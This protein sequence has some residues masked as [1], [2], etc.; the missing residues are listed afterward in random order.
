VIPY[1]KRTSTISW[2]DFD[3]TG[4][5]AAA[6]IRE[7]STSW[8]RVVEETQISNTVILAGL[9]TTSAA[10]VMGILYR[11]SLKKVLNQRAF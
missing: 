4:L 1:Q 7:G 10:A 5:G 2:D 8:K 9:A 11:E 6:V 3:I